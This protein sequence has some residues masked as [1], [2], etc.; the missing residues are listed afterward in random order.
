[1][2]RD[3]HRQHQHQHEDPLVGQLRAEYGGRVASGL[4]EA[5]VA[6][7][8]SGAARGQDPLSS[9]HLA[10]AEVAS[11]AATASRAHSRGRR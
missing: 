10:R 11:L 1:M 5:R 4:I 9:E 7:L 3:H 6:T 2:R 8:C